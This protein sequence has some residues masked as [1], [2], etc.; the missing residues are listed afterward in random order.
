MEESG[1]IYVT[2]TTGEYEL[3]KEAKRLAAS[4]R[5][6]TV[7]RPRQAPTEASKEPLPIS[8]WGSKRKQLEV[9]P[10]HP[11]R[12][13]GIGYYQLEPQ[14]QSLKK[15]QP[16][17]FVAES[18]Q[19]RDSKKGKA[20][21]IPEAFLEDPDEKVPFSTRILNERLPKGYRAPSIREYDG[22][23]DPEDH[24]RKFKST[25][26]LHQYSDAVKCRAFLNTLSGSALKWF[27]GLPQGSITCFLDFKT[28]FLRRFAS[29][30]KYQKTD[31]YLFA[32]K[33]GS[34]EPLRSYINRF[35]QVAQDVPTATSEILM[36]AFSHGLGEGEWKKRKQ[37]ERRPKDHFLPLPSRKGERLNP[38]LN[39]YRESGKP[40]LH[41]FHLGPEIRP[42]PRVAAVHIPRPGLGSNRYC[43]YHRSRTHDTNRCFQFARDSKRA[44]EMSLPPP[45]LAPQ[46]IK[47]MEDQRMAGQAGSSRPDLAGP[48]THQPGRGK[49]PEG[50][51]EVENR[52]NAAVREIDMI[53]GGPTDGDSGR[54]RKSHVRRLEV[55]AVG[56][57]QEQA[58]G[59]VLSFGPA[60]L[61][62]LELPHDDAL[63]IKAII[64]NS[65]V[66][67]VFVDTGS[68]VN[69]LFRTAFEEMQ[70]DAVELQPVATSLY[71][72]TG[73]EVKP[74]GQI[75]LAISLGTE[76]LVRTRRSTIIVVDS[77]SSYNVILGRPALHEFRAAVSTFHQK[78]KFP[79]GEQVGEVKGEQ[80]VSR[81]CYIDMVRVEA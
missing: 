57:S 7:S 77:P 70:I 17:A 61:E 16:Q 1:R 59:P 48:S 35:N 76:P 4:E 2:M 19:P 15:E 41:A 79:V 10:Q 78:I 24:L 23:K 13:P 69:I 6:V 66:A 62:G 21:V 22:S 32:L 30:K 20:L 33:Q 36:S 42:A 65:R 50:S 52:G 56:C 58:A 80:K 60:D 45:E 74:M 81:R 54:A 51:R 37:L 49:E 31:H 71:G 46:L 44:A 11:Y 63:I 53:S 73:N 26:L 68:S 28:T 9:V 47:M 3:F 29:S 38:P 75:K 14:A 40:D 64:A 34:T 67:R 5:Q 55:H 27:D 25:A 12:V 72:F 39:P 18:S 43:T 8:D